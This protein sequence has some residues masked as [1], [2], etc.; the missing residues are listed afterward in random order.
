MSQFISFRNTKLHFTV[1]GDGHVV[2]LLHGFLMSS[3]TWTPLIKELNNKYKV[4]AID[5]PGHGKSG[6]LKTVHSM[7]IMA[8]AVHEILVHLN[9]K[10]FV[11]IGHSMGGYV[12]LAYAHKYPEKLNGLVLVNSTAVADTDEK[13]QK[14][15]QA[16]AVVKNNKEAFVKV[17]ISNLFRAENRSRLSQKII[18]IINEA[19][20]MK[21]SAI[22]SALEG[23]K[24]RADHLKLFRELPLSK[25]V[26]IGKKDTVIPFDLV[27][28]QLK[29]SDIEMKE[30]PDGHMSYIENYK[31]FTYILMHFIEKI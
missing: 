14:R 27:K 6:S 13:K 15:D 9:I 20:K 19:L 16:K 8:D 21:S 4:V 3:N 1:T 18:T 23:M 2:V 10:Q 12:A 28:D 5:L 24:L 25:L 30:L 11:M 26:I 31:E 17:F 29:N 7:P 22:I